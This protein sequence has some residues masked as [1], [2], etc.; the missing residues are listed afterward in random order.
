MEELMGSVVAIDFV[1]R[2][3]MSLPAEVLPGDDKSEAIRELLTT[4]VY[5]EAT[6]VGEDACRAATALIQKV[7]E[8]MSDDVDVAARLADASSQRAC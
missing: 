6:A 7:V 8:R 5:R 3:L 4:S 1:L 2:T